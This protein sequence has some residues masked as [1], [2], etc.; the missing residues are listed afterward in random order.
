MEGSY[1]LGC[2]CHKQ[3]NKRTKIQTKKLGISMHL[4]TT[5]FHK[6]CNSLAPVCAT[7]HGKI[8]TYERRNPM[9]FLPRLVEL[10]CC[11]WSQW[12]NVMPSTWTSKV[13]IKRAVKH[14]W[15]CYLTDFALGKFTGMILEELSVLISGFTKVQEVNFAC[16]ELCHVHFTKVEI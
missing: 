8:S 6:T 7:E 9:A 15:I 2:Q 16:P 11:C 1:S 4:A 13:S 3:A 14:E 10:L 12:Y 5:D